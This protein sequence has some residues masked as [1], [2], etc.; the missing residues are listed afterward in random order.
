VARIR[1]FSVRFSAGEFIQIRLAAEASALAP[2]AWVRRQA[3]HAAVPKAEPAAGF[4]PPPPACP[5]AKLTHTTTARFTEEQF[6]ALDDYARRCCL[7]VAAYIR[8]VVLGV[9]LVARRPLAHAAIVAVNRVGNNLNQLVHLAHTGVVLPPEPL[10]AVAEVRGE[11]QTLRM[12]LLKA[13][14]ADAPEAS[15]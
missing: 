12:A 13:E 2:A 8:Q 9:K 5:P 1:L 7:P 10:R 6:Q 4:R 11:L 15:A 14:E 3:L